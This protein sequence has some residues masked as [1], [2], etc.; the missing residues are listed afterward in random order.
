MPQL[1]YRKPIVLIGRTQVDA[2]HEKTILQRAHGVANDRIVLEVDLGV[3]DE[4]GTFFAGDRRQRSAFHRGCA[5]AETGEHRIDIKTLCHAPN[6]TAR[7]PGP[8]LFVVLQAQQR[9]DGARHVG[10]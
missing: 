8:A 4:P 10:S 2:Q 5:I 6:G 1:I 9:I 3:F 7:P